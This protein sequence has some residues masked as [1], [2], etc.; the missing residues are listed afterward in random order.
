M[1]TSGSVQHRRYTLQDVKRIN[2]AAGRHFFDRS[3]M[4]GFGNTLRDIRVYHV[5]E[6]S[7]GTQEIYLRV[8][9]HNAPDGCDPINVWEFNPATGDIRH[10]NLSDSDLYQMRRHG[11]TA[12]FYSWLKAE[13][14]AQS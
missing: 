3:T 10:T 12:A 11:F 9:N 7:T 1:S 14:Y 8:H 6:V 2:I 4:R 13:T 5:R